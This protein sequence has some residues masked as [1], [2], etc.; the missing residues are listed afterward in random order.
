MKPK[1][2][3]RTVVGCALVAGVGFAFYAGVQLAT[4]PIEPTEVVQYAD[5][6]D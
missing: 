3:V 4:A 1:K 6:A 5:F 2:I